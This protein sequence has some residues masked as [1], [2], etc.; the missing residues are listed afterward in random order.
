MTNL[1]IKSFANNVAIV[2]Y[3]EEYYDKEI[4]VPDEYVIDNILNES[5]FLLYASGFTPDV[6][7][8]KAT[9][10]KGTKLF[11][12]STLLND[13]L[14]NVLNSINAKHGDEYFQWTSDHL[15][16]VNEC[17]Y[18]YRMHST[19]INVI[20]NNNIN[21]KKYTLALTNKAILNET[22]RLV[23]LDYSYKMPVDSMKTPY[24]HAFDP[25]T[26]EA[27]IRNFFNGKTMITTLDE[28]PSKVIVKPI[29]G[30]L[31]NC[32][33]YDRKIYENADELINDIIS[34]HG[35]LT[36]FFNNQS[37]KKFILSEENKF[38]CPVFL[39]HYHQDVFSSF[40]YD[41]VVYNTGNNKYLQNDIHE[42]FKNVIDAL[43][44]ACHIKNAYITCSGFVN[45]D[46]IIFITDISLSF[47]PL[48]ESTDSS[49]LTNVI[50]YM[51]GLS[52]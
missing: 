48:N 32:R 51:Y 43:I 44:T 37:Q 4:V 23:N 36:T 5:A 10:D 15:Q 27:T 14:I 12:P 52:D 7:P 41:L 49:K 9:R 29:Y 21:N 18:D 19:C 40:N 6:I 25:P 39:Q 13:N 28:K 17:L 33:I 46:G 24:I 11:V 8:V 42:R 2:S 1:T 38:T 3:G 35:D 34:V 30:W 22:L 31:E 50:E 45:N 16:N 47:Y 26:N 20:D